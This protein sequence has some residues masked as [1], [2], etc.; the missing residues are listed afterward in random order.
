MIR[1]FITFLVIVFSSNAFSATC[2]PQTCSDNKPFKNNSVFDLADSP[3]YK[4]QKSNC[5]DNKLFKNNAVFDSI[6]SPCY[7]GQKGNCRDTFKRNCNCEKPKSTCDNCEK[8]PR[9]KVYVKNYNPND[10]EAYS[11]I[12]RGCQDF[13]PI[14]FEYVD[15]R[16]KTSNKYEAYSNK[17]GNYRFRIFG[18][19]R[20]DKEAYLNVGRLMQKDMT[21]FETF[22]KIYGDCFNQ[23][24]MPVDLCDENNPNP[25]PEYILT[26]EITDYFMNVCDKFDWAQSKAKGERKGNSEITITWRLMDISKNNVYWKGE[27][28]GYGEV[29]YG[30]TNGELLLVDRAFED[31]LFQLR[32]LEGF[33]E[34]LATRQTPQQM[35]DHKNRLATL[36]KAI[37]PVKC[38]YGEEITAIEVATEEKCPTCP[39]CPTLTAQVEEPV[40][41]VEN[42]PAETKTI[43]EI[44]ENSGS[45]SS[46]SGVDENNGID[47]YGNVDNVRIVEDSWIDIP[48]NDPGNKIAQEN[49][50]IVEDAFFKTSG[51]FCIE[52]Q[53][54]Y[55]KMNPQNLYRVRA[56]IVDVANNSGQK[57]VGLIINDQFILT[58]ADLLNKEDNNFN[59]KTINGVEFKASAFRLSPNKNVA[60]LLMQEK[61]EYTPLA[62]N[63]ELPPVG[64]KGFMTLGLNLEDG[65][66]GYVDD[67]TEIT[68][69]RFSESK[70][71]EIIT[72][73]HTQNQTL[74]GALVDN[75]G[76]IYGLAHYGKRLTN[77]SD[78]FIPIESA[79]KSLDVELCGREFLNQ[80]PWQKSSI[81]KTQDQTPAEMKEKEKK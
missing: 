7:K 10:N 12:H 40:A 4:G 79:L 42:T 3:C 17:L 22:N 48:L 28:I 39:E 76:N 19:R 2:N 56:S 33:E 29:E 31:A 51:K 71:A 52:N 25:F 34:Q 32:N 50:Q 44:D 53:L 66:E 57:G 45:S 68:G 37:N 8:K 16:I 43:V 70:G 1:F 6:D 78:M 54:V 21:F 59:I 46:S 69:Y 41:I 77:E 80:A 14:S 30:E 35:Q 13:A 38:Q 58:S 67:S 55:K 75:K 23:V 9:T 24:K 72:N 15:F 49:R 26:A 64:S 47:S 81:E 73:K 18:C 61:T 36:E 74:G 27:S 62:L 5:S 65:G 63:L 20:A 60:L 11:Y